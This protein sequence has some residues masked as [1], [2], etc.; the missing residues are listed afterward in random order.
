[1]VLAVST[2]RKAALPL[3]AAPHNEHRRLD[4]QAVTDRCGHDR[5][6]S[7]ERTDDGEA[8]ESRLASGAPTPRSFVEEEAE[9]HLES[10]PD[11]RLRWRFCR[12]AVV[13]AYGELCT[14]PPP[15]SAMRVPTLLVHATQFGLVREEQLDE[16]ASSSNEHVEVTGVPGGHIVYWDAYEETAD[17]VEKF[18]LR[19]SD[20]S[21]A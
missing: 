2:W 7:S 6:C 15:P 19:H 16:Y 14:D 11:G 10:S 8:I 12:S 20:V 17:A 1:M 21:H 3:L 18:L 5:A 4:G 13:T 9:E